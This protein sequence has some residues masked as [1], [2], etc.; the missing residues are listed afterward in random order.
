[1]TDSLPVSGVLLGAN[2][3]TRG[4]SHWCAS[5]QNAKSCGAG[6]E[7]YCRDKVWVGNHPLAAMTKPIPEKL[8]PQKEILPE[9]AE[10]MF[11]R[12]PMTEQEKSRAMGKIMNPVVGQYTD[13][14]NGGVS[15]DLVYSVLFMA[16][17]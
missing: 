11:R 4:P 6:S 5:I 2:K 14:K 10:P 1:M 15:E 16:E 9:E 13:Q 12:K 7:K 3:C 17:F 8:V